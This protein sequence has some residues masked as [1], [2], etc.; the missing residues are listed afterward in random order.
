MVK[1][2]FARLTMDYTKPYNHKSDNKKERYIIPVAIFLVTILMIPLGGTNYL[3][4]LF[5]AFSFAYIT[6]K[7]DKS[8]ELEDPTINIYTRYFTIFIYISIVVGII[9][10][11]GLRTQLADV[12]TSSLPLMCMSLGSYY[13]VRHDEK[14]VY[15]LL[16]IIL[17]IELICGAGQNINEGFRDFMFKLYD[18]ESRLLSYEAEDVGRAVGTLKSPNYYGIVCVSLGTVF[19]GLQF[20]AEAR[21]NMKKGFFNLLLVFITGVIVVLS[22]SKTSVVCLAFVFVLCTF[23]SSS[24][25]KTGKFF[26]LIFCIA[27]IF[28]L[29]PIFEQYSNR[30]IDLSSMSGRSDNWTKIIELGFSKN[31]GRIFLGYGNGY[32]TLQ[33]L[34]VYAD[35]FYILL[36][37][38]QGVIGAIAYFVTWISIGINIL[39][40]KPTIYR[41]YAIM[42]ICI[43]ILSDV[44]AAITDMPIACIVI[45]Y[46]IG[47]YSTLSVSKQISVVE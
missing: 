28:I 8:V 7:K 9:S 31:P 45:Y 19:I 35:S 10:G 46:M 2:V 21:K 44:T 15:K 41:T 18:S 33:N 4:I 24:M 14:E 5:A 27:A 20:D 36:L 1:G 25:N 30:T 34:G 32:S 47:R 39:N 26:I 22:V 3:Q 38:E 13:A 43:V 11:V 17:V 12:L 40:R 37:F 16:A 6:F 29:I 23:F 42:L